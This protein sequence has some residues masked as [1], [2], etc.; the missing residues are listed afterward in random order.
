MESLDIALENLGKLKRKI[1]V[2]V[3]LEKVQQA[4][5]KTYDSLRNKVNVPGFRKGKFPQSLL[6]KRFKKVMKNEAVETL[7]PEYFEKAIKQENLKLAV[8]PNFDHQEM[9]IDKKKPLVFHATFEVLPDFPVPE[10][11][12]FSLEKQ[13]ITVS[14]E[15]INEHKQRHLD[16]AA[17]YEGKEGIAEEGDQLVFDYEGKLDEEIIAEQQNQTYNLGSK[18]FLPEFEDA[19]QGMS[20][21]EETNF[22]LTFPADYKEEK[23]QGKT[24]GFRVKLKEIKAK[25]PLA[26]DENFFQRYGEKVKS[27]EDFIKLVTDEVNF[28]KEGEINNEYRTKIKE[29]LAEMLEFEV[30]EQLLEEEMKF[31]LNQARQ[32]EQQK[33]TPEEELKEKIAGEAAK[34][35]R[36]SIFTQKML[37]QEDIKVDE[38][39]VQRKFE[40]NCMLLGV[41]SEQLLQQDY[42]QQIYQ[43]TYGIVS[44]ETVLDYTIEKVL[45][46]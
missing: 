18:Q 4:Y 40:I 19:L 32:D 42:G 11:A 33:D 26:M 23:L 5:N 36:F 17:T 20:K 39:E 9:E 27:E 6:E 38:K 45:A 3:P 14:D 10:Y 7:V 21:D 30:P 25:K 2:T 24:A 34:S 1:T 13:E 12:S 37:E 46:K 22:N 44:D 28:R 15:E 16:Q 8:K 31:R 41:K 43:R 35:L 29:Q